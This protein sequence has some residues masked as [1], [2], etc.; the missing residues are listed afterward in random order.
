MHEIYVIVVFETAVAIF[1]AQTG[2]FLEEHVITDRL[3]YRAG[4]LN[5][6]TGDIMLLAYNTSKASNIIQTTIFQLK[7]IPA[8]DQIDF[9]LN[10]CRFQEARDIFNLKENK[11][12]GDFAAKTNQFDLDVGWIRFT[13]ML[14]FP[15]MLNDFKRTD[16]DPRE[17]VL[18]HKYLLVS[19]AGSEKAYTESL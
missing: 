15:N 5:H 1:N 7:E 16:L 8:Q 19:P 4:C 3:K 11:G 17:L 10:G 14:D 13:R 12:D 18:M 9:L 6:Q 2:D